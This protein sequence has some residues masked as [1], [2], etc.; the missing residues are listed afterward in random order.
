MWRSAPLN[1][2]VGLNL[3]GGLGAAAGSICWGPSRYV[4]VSEDITRILDSHPGPVSCF[5][6]D[7]SEFPSPERLRRWIEA[8]AEKQAQVVIML[9]LTGPPDMEAPLHHLRSRRL[10]YLAVGFLSIRE[11]LPLALEA[12]ELEGHV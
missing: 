11:C 9:N 3:D 7:A 4:D 1:L 10:T 2:D 12:A 8:L 5:R 6:M